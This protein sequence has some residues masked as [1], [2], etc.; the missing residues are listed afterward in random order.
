MYE[1]LTR[2]FGTVHNRPIPYT[3]LCIVLFSV[4]AVLKQ[5][6]STMPRTSQQRTR[7][8]ATHHLHYIDKNYKLKLANGKTGCIAQAGLRATKKREKKNVGEITETN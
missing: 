4:F 6:L 8:R 7:T 3:K 5:H 1:K 2:C